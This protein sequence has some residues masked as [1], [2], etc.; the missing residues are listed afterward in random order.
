M[1]AK[2]ILLIDDAEIWKPVVGYEDEYEVS[3]FGR[4]R[5]FNRT[6][7]HGVP[8]IAQEL[9][10]SVNCR[11]G[12]LDIGLCKG[13][14]KRRFKVHVL[15]ATAFKG[16]KPTPLHEVRHLDGAKRN[17]SASNLE[18]G[19]TR[20]NADDKIVHG[21]ARGVR[22]SQAVLDEE[23]VRIIRARTGAGHS[24][25]DIARDLGVN[26]AT[27]YDVQKKRRWNHV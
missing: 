16:P 26:R 2:H 25:A 3:N 13:G 14:K 24:G 23:K 7:P 19:T 11:S 8:R 18:W 12:Y 4:V 15:V 6:D 20:D 22:N 27:V 21:S 10:Q 5:S 9:K 1:A 17:N